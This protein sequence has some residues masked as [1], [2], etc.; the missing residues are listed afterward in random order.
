MAQVL[1]MEDAAAVIAAITHTILNVER[2]NQAVL[3]A[4]LEERNDF[5]E[6]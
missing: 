6:G 1:S 5:V 3:V 4:F 2:M